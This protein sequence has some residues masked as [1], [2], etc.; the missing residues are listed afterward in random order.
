MS[1]F[2]SCARTEC[3]A[4]HWAI[5]VD[6]LGRRAENRQTAQ[7]G[8]KPRPAGPQALAVSSHGEDL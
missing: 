4:L 5:S 8:F 2:S 3:Q 7:L 1:S 6:D